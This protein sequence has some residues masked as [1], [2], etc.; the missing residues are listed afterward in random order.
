[1]PRATFLTLIHKCSKGLGD[2]TKDASGTTW[3]N[4]KPVLMSTSATSAMKSVT[5]TGT[6]LQRHMEVGVANLDHQAVMQMLQCMVGVV[7][8]IATM[9]DFCD[10]CLGCL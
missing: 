3:I 8:H 9:T 6:A 7:V 4:L 10:S 2:A 5:P 1:M